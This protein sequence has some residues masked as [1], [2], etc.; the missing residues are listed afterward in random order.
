[1]ISKEQLFESLYSWDSDANQRLKCMSAACVRNRAAGVAIR[2]S[3]PGYG[4]EA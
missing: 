4:L 3:G 2:C 1:M